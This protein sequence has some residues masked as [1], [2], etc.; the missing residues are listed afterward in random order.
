M[1]PF[2]GRDDVDVGVDD[3]LEALLGAGDGAVAAIRFAPR[4]PLA[5]ARRWQ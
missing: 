4:M 3:H 5:T 2:V 1:T